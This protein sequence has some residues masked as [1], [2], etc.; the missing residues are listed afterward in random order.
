MKKSLLI[1]HL[2]LLSF[3][4]FPQKLQIHLT[5]KNMPEWQITDENYFIVFAGSTYFS[6]D[7]V[8]FSLEVNKRYYL[9]L[10]VGESFSGDESHLLLYI[11]DEPVILVTPSIGTGDHFLPF[12]TGIRE[13]STK[14]TGGTDALVSDFPWQ[15]YITAG[16]MACG[17]SIIDDEWILTAAHCVIDEDGNP[18]PEDVVAVKVG[19]DNPYN[20]LEGL[21]FSASRVIPHENYDEETL[22]NDIALIRLGNPVQNAS[23]IRLVTAADVA[24]GAT[25]PGVMTWVTGWGLI[26]LDP[27]VFPTSLQKVQLPIITNAQ[28][29]TVWQSIPSTV[30]MAGYKDG[31]KDACNGDSGGP[32]VVE[33]LGEYRLA[34][35]VSW[36]SSECDT[37]GAYTNVS[38]FEE[39]IRSNTGI[40]PPLIP[41]AITGDTVV[42]SGSASTSYTVNPTPGT[43]SYEW[44]LLPDEAGGISI[45]QNSAVISWNDDFTGVADLAYRI[46]TGGLI[47]EW[48]RVQI[49]VVDETRFISMPEDAE[50]CEGQTITLQSL[51]E[52]Y[53]LTYTWYFNGEPVQSG[54]QSDFRIRAAETGESGTYT[55]SAEGYCG[56]AQS[57]PVSLVV[58]RQTGIISVSPDISIPFG[59]DHILYVSAEGHNLTYQWEKDSEVIPG[60]G[61]DA[62]YL[63]DVTAEDIGNYR[64]RVSGTCG[65]EISDSSYVFVTNDSQPGGD[66]VYLWPT[67]TSDQFNIALGSDLEYEVRIFNTSGQMIRVYR[68]LRFQNIINISHLPG[69]LYI[70]SVISPDFRKSIKIIKN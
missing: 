27:N 31:N 52:G 33:V 4:V 6:S 49:K 54:I 62:L 59:S 65:T 48:T 39:W 42:C 28:A 29:S 69:G 64:V 18:L 26:S 14:I 51:A 53:N 20:D 70:V 13:M 57:N 55:V 3:T 25:A 24:Y 58:N 10:S 50:I 30:L 17:G 45:T 66:V 35:L 12:Y 38:L 32:M 2:L 56:M 23:P 11:E 8:T 9:Q 16:N 47:S 21:V 43:E 44:V 19:A 68:N 7:S 60:F 63:Q 37:Y 5:G 41:P 34:G 22:E 40:D 61:S 15:V 46:V 67:I 36:G 1:A